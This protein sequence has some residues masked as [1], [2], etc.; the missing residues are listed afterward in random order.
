MSRKM[1]SYPLYGMVA[2]ALLLFFFLPRGAHSSDSGYGYQGSVRQSSMG[3]VTAS[4]A[5]NI[6]RDIGN[7][8]VGPDEIA[9]ITITQN[10]PQFTDRVGFSARQLYECSQ[11][12]GLFYLPALGKNQSPVT[13]RTIF[14]D[15]PQWFW[16]ERFTTKSLTEGWLLIPLRV[17]NPPRS[18]GARGVDAI[19]AAWVLRHTPPHLIVGRFYTSDLTRGGDRVIVSRDGGGSITIDRGARVGSSITDMGVG[20][21]SGGDFVSIG[22]RPGLHREQAPA[23]APVREQRPSRRQELIDKAEGKKK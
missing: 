16:G 13:I 12:C 11:P 9:D 23:T 22:G 14:G 17:T 4:E 19:T 6:M 18:M 15:S 3:P 10:T 20:D 21:L 2:V 7:V 8:F 1:K 5:R